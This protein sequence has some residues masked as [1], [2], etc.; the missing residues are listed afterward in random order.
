M[1]TET[2][3]GIQEKL[4]QSQAA[5][6]KAMEMIAIFSAATIGFV[7]AIRPQDSGET[8]IEIKIAIILL[9][10]STLSTIFWFFGKGNQYFKIINEMINKPNEVARVKEPWWARTSRVLALATFVS[11]YYY[12]FIS[13]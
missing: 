9:F 1:D 6:A 4:K 12:L 13:L 8:S 2:A 3:N 7:V 11:A 10:I 5:Y